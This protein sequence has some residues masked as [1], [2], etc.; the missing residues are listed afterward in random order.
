[1]CVNNTWGTVCDDS[2]DTAHAQVVCRELGYSSVDTV[3]F[4]ST[5][6]GKGNASI[7]LDNVKCVG[8][9]STLFS[10]TY[11]TNQNCSDFEEV[12]IRCMGIGSI[13]IVL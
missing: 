6:F 4:N 3:A 9:E 5:Y 12:G 13:L 2:W 7:I 10:C 11:N 8:N 1:M